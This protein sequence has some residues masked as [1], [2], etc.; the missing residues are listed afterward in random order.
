[1]VCRRLRGKIVNLLL[2]K[3]M[4]A[5]Y[6]E[7]HAIGKRYRRH[8]E[9]GTPFCVTVDGRQ[10]NDQVVTVRDRDT[11]AQER[12][13]IDKLDAHLQEKFSVKSSCLDRGAL[14]C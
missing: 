11:M 12:V 1:M 14:A 10:F 7:Q 9:A 2:S 5:S 6:D 4:N 3:G 13:A 8:D